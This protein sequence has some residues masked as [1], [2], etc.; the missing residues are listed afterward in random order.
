ME[1][2][3]EGIVLSQTPYK[4]KDSMINVL[5]YK[6]RVGF[7]ARGILSLSSKNASSCLLYSHSRFIL[8]SRGENLTLRKG[9]LI[10]SFYNLYESIESMTLLGLISE[11]ILKI[12]DEDDGRI[13]PIYLRILNLLKDGFD[14]LTLLAIFLAKIINY[15]G[16]ALNYSSCVLCGSKKGIVGV[17]YNQ[18]GFICAK[19]YQE[20]NSQNNL[21]LKSFRYIFMVDL[22]DYDKVVLNKSIA[23]KLI[24]ELLDYL[25]DKFQLRKFNAEEL[26]FRSLNL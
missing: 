17:D 24:K 6:G 11:V 4:E 9:E 1:I 5:T 25:K 2:E 19:C 7:Y 22:I 3:I 16:Y 18:G 21:Y 10:S 26:F 8:S 23:L 13:Y 15:S 14:K 20:I 12:V